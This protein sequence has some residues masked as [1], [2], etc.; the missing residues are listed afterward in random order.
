[1]RRKTSS[2][3]AASLIGQ[4]RNM[5]TAVGFS[6]KVTNDSGPKTQT[7]NYLDCVCDCGNAVKVRHDRFSN[8]WTKSCGCLW[9]AGPRPIT[10]ARKSAR[11][12]SKTPLY[13]RWAAMVSRCK[14]PKS[15]RYARYGGRGITVCNRWLD[16]A[17]FLEDMGPPPA[18]MTLD[19]INNDGN[20]EPQNCRWATV[21]QQ[22]NNTSKNIR[23]VYEGRLVTL[24][25]LAVLVSVPLRALTEHVTETQK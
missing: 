10:H 21:K 5:L 4:K 15:T 6:H 12:L 8:G 13:R 16:F 24:S 17:N 2:E 3:V 23:C 18:G 9:T 25:E 11:G 14:N 22:A 20:Y 7:R 19:R 1:M